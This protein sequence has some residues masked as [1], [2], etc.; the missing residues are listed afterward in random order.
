MIISGEEMGNTARYIRVPQAYPFTF[1]L[2][3]PEG[4]DTSGKT[5]KVYLVSASGTTYLV[6]QGSGA[7]E[8]QTIEISCDPSS[9]PVEAAYKLQAAAD[10]SG[11][12]PIT[13]CPNQNTASNVYIYVYDMNIF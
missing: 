8:R 2:L 11:Q 5:I 12:N 10:I 7:A 6:G 3:K 13:V 4:A 9:V 1:R